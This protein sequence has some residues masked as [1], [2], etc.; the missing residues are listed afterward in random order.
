MKTTLMYCYAFNCVYN[1]E[2]F[3]T[4][5][6]TRNGTQGICMDRCFDEHEDLREDLK[7]FLKDR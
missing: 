2:G 3:C 6:E 4:K 5:K 7:T 1:N